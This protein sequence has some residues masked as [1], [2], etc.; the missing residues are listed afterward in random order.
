MSSSPR[1][2]KQHHQVIGCQALWLVFVQAGQQVVL[3]CFNGLFRHS[4]CP[5][6]LDPPKA[7]TTSIKT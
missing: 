7:F 2:A 5:T 6:R 3:R 1:E 4:L